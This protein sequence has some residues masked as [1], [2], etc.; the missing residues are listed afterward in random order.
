M[1]KIVFLL[2]KNPNIKNLKLKSFLSIYSE[3]QIEKKKENSHYSAIDHLSGEIVFIHKFMNCK[4]INY[5]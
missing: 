3:K 1:E 4:F 2:N 5:E